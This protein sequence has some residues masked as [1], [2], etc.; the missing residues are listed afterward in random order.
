MCLVH[1]T[2]A[3]FSKVVGCIEHT[4]STD[5]VKP[6]KDTDSMSDSKNGNKP[7]DSDKSKKRR[8]LYVGTQSLG[9]RRDHME[10]FMNFFVLYFYFECN[11]WSLLFWYFLCRLFHLSK[12]VLLLIG[13]LLITYGIMLSG[14]LHITIFLDVIFLDFGIVLQLLLQLDLVSYQVIWGKYD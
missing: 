13:T 14:I 3:C 1:L 5:S 10:V 9:Y 2:L 11:V 7:A 12:T 4:G 6:E 8:S